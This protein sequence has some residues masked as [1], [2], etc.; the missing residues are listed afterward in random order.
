MEKITNKVANLLPQ[1]IVLKRSKVAWYQKVLVSFMVFYKVK[2]DVHIL[3]R[4]FCLLRLK[5]KYHDKRDVD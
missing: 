1:F 5:Y 3:V 2:S 4:D